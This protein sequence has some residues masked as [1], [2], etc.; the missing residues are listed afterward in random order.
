M[1]SSRGDILL[2]PK[3]LYFPAGK[4]TDGRTDEQLAYDASIR[5]VKMCVRTYGTWLVRRRVRSISWNLPPIPTYIPSV[6]TTSEYA[7]KA[8]K[9]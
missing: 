9:T 8:R 4:R 6:V 5:R 3:A 2:L 7:S 1:E